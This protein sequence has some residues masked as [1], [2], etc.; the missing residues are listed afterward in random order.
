MRYKR[1]RKSS[2]QTDTVSCSLVK[3]KG[4][5]TAAT[6][7]NCPSRHVDVSPRY[8]VANNQR[9]WHENSPVGRLLAAVHEARPSGNKPGIQIKSW[10]KALAGPVFQRP[11]GWELRPMFD[12]ASRR[13]L[14]FHAARVKGS[15]G[16]RRG[17][18]AGRGVSRA[19]VHRVAGALW[20]TRSLIQDEESSTPARADPHLRH[21]SW[22]PASVAPGLRPISSIAGARVHHKGAMPAG[23]GRVRWR[24]KLSPVH[25]TGALHAWPRRRYEPGDQALAGGL[26]AVDL[27]KLAR[28]RG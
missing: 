18:Q 22:S 5:I 6:I 28:Q 2:R 4:R 16:A 26:V 7:C 24:H 23:R 25:P 3:P 9:R 10:R 27:T 19:P 13:I 1:T 12:A 11:R 8:E 21:P 20:P 17:L 14:G 15:P